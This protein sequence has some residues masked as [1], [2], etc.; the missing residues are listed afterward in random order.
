MP[1]SEDFA[2]IR[3]YAVRAANIIGAG[4]QGFPRSAVAKLNVGV[5][6]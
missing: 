6:A 2:A 4:R 5:A 3:S 1:A